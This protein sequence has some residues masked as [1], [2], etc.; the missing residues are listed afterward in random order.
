ML[1]DLE[2]VRKGQ[3]PPH[4]HQDVDMH[5]L[6]DLERKGETVDIP[7]PEAGPEVWSHPMVIGLLAAVGISVLV[8]VVLLV[9]LSSR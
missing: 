9:V 7:V 1:E 4:A 8:N 5:K 6:V 2:A 3:P